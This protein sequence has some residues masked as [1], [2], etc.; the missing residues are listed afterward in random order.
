VRNV[1]EI[2]IHFSI[3]ARG[4]SKLTFTQQIRYLEHLS[5]LYDFYYPRASPIAKFLIATA[6]GWLAGLVVYLAMIA[7]GNSVSIAAIASYPLAIV[8]TALF[9]LRYVRAQREFLVASH[10]WIDFAMISVTEWA[11]CSLAAIWLSHR[12]ALP[13]PMEVF[14][15]AYGLAT[16]A[17]YIMRKELLQDLRG[18]RQDLR[19]QELL[20]PPLR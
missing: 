15:Y 5:R 1:R 13:H 16:I 3:R 17:R 20:N 12:L 8:I 19:K 14:V 11:V 9:H 4:E 10:P 7:S 2:P 18:L 6:S